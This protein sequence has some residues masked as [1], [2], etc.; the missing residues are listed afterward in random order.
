MTV[1]KE[2]DRAAW[3]YKFWYRGVPYK[4]STGQLTRDDAEEF[5][6]DLKRKVRRE[7]HGLVVLPQHTPRI[8]EFANVYVAHLKQQIKEDAPHLTVAQVEKRLQPTM[9]LLRVVL[10]FW[11]PRPTGSNPKN[12]PVEGEPYHDLR[13]ADPIRDRSWLQKFEQWIKQRQV[14]VGKNKNGEQ[15]FRPIGK[16]TRLHYMSIMSRLY[17]V[18]NLPDY[19]KQTG[20]DDKNPFLT[21]ARARPR[22]RKVTVTPAELRAWLSAA[23]K[24]TKLAIAIAALAPKLRLAN[25]LGLRWSQNIIGDLDYIKVDEHKTVDKTGEPLVVPIEPSLRT[26]LRAAKGE[27]SS[28]HVITYRSKP[29]K[30]IRGGVRRSAEDA[31]LTYGRD[32]VGGVTFHSIRHTAATLLAEVPHL[33]EAMRA[34]AMGQDIETTQGYTHIRPLKQRPA[35]AHLGRKL[36]LDDIFARAFGGPGQAPGVLVRKGVRKLQQKR[37]VTKSRRGA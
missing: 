5:E 8:G 18:A 37:T 29:V 21:V 2:K 1:W 12:P 20:V 6:E 15:V 31:D 30:S 9:D 32:V 23:P 11:G 14:Y 10:R 7:A 26:I 33:T 28:D 35:L 13:L 25:V 16:Q 24:H 22:G 3:R 27:S 17:R 34:A 4:G 19:A 36:R